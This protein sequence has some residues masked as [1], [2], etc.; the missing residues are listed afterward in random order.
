MSGSLR[1]HELSMPGFPVLHYLPEFLQTHVHWVSDAIQP[2]YLIST[3]FSPCH[4]SF[5]ANK[6]FSSELALHIRWPKYWSFSFSISFS[7]EYW[8]LISFRTEEFDFPCR[9]RNSQESFPAPQFESVN[10]LVL[11]LLYGSTLTF[12]H[13]YR[14]KP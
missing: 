8:G 14:K 9:P 12:I 5:P 11:S 4:Q 1:P 7:N 6:V 3:P 10:S 13:D 2:S